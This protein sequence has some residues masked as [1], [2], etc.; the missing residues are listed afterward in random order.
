MMN[1]IKQFFRTK[2]QV[3]LENRNLQPWV[4][5]KLENLEG[6]HDVTSLIYAAPS[7][8]YMVI[9]AEA[10]ALRNAHDFAQDFLAW[11]NEQ[12]QIKVTQVEP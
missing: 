6:T 7:S 9:T 1:Y 10:K 3:D 8:R 11:G 2:F 12:E 4:Y 5:S